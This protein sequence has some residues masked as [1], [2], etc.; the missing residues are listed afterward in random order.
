MRSRTTGSWADGRSPCAC[1]ELQLV[2]SEEAIMRRLLPTILLVVATADVKAAGESHCALFVDNSWLCVSL[3]H[4]KS[5]IALSPGRHPA[6]GLR[7]LVE[8]D[9]MIE[10]CDGVTISQNAFVRLRP[11]SLRYGGIFYSDPSNEF[12][13]EEHIVASCRTRGGAG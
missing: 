5:C 8:S 2:P 13:D 9:K 3:P 11:F 7:C 1:I 10:K 6:T 12:Y 4:S